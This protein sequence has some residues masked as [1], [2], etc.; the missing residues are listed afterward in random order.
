MIEIDVYVCP[1][2]EIT[3]FISRGHAG[4]AVDG[5]DIVCSAVS[6]AVYMVVNTVTDVLGLTP[7]VFYV[8]DGIMELEIEKKDA[9]IART[10]MRGL[11]I[12]LID[13]EEQYSKYMRVS[14]MEV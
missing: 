14:Y 8:D 11:K 12:H 5:S 4:F 7:K 10:I 2:G 6:S 9:V 1:D 3:G 13:L